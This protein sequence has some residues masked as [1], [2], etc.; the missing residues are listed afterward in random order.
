[1]GGGWEVA[2]GMARGR[3]VAGWWWMGGSQGTGGGREVARRWS[4]DGRRMGGGRKLARGW[5]QGVDGRWPGGG[6][7]GRILGGVAE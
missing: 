4:G 7:D 2:G 5:G 3:E 1:M 6:Q